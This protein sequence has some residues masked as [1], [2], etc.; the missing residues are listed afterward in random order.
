MRTKSTRTC[1]ALA[2]AVL[3][4]GVALASPF[5][6]GVDGWSAEELAVLSSMQLSELPPTQKDPSN[7]YEASPAAVSLGERIFSDRRFS[8]NG[9]VSCASCHHPDKEFQDGWPLGLGVGTGARR[10]MPVVA[11]GYSPFLFWDGRKDSLWSQAL[12]PLEDPAEHGGN[13]LAYAHVLQAYYRVEY[14][15]VFGAM[16][17]LSH[18]PR[19]AGP[20]GTPAQQAAWSAIGEEARREVSRV[21]ANMGKALAAYQKTLQYTESRMDRYVEGVVKRDPAAAQLLDA[22]EKNGLRLFIGKGQCITCHNGPLLTDHHFHNTGV[23]PRK[24]EQPDIGRRAALA[25]VSADEFNCLGR[26]S[27]AEPEQCEE[28][29]FLAADDHAMEAAFKVPSLRNAALRPPYMHAGQIE[30]LDEMSTLL[31]T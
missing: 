27:D 28:L 8:G 30:S 19:E 13:R 7:A 25:K 6:S 20:L 24:L 23:T 26:F 12:G 5:S 31:P 21:F 3:A 18:L 22:R 10:T 1:I 4:A 17:D 15:A 11:A 2:G 29:R 14:E 9:A 16:P